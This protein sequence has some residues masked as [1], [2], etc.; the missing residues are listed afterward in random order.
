ISQ[1]AI[2]ADGRFV[3]FLFRDDTPYDN[4][5]ADVYV[6]DRSTGKYDRVS[7]TPGDAEDANVDTGDP[8]ISEDGR[9]VAFASE[10]SKLVPGD[11]N[12]V[13]DIFVH[14]RASGT[15]ERASVAGDGSQATGDAIVGSYGP[16][17]SAQGRFVTFRSFAD[18]LVPGDS[19]GKA[20]LFV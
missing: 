7:G 10:D 19:N 11:S 18:D 9:F 4:S 6:Y 16:S 2:S 14:D 8:A 1:P 12:G 5:S 3:A 20:D 17:M 13:S 15:T